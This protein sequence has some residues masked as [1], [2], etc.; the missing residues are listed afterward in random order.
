MTEANNGDDPDADARR[1]SALSLA[2]DDATGWFED[3][4]AAASTG[5]AVVP[6]D[7]VQ[8]QV[9]VEEWVRDQGDG[10]GRRALVVGCALGR[11]AELV[12]GMGYATTGFDIAPTA[13]EQAR[14]RHPDSAVDY[15]V[16]DLLDPPSQWREAFDLVVESINVQALPPALRERAVAQI[17]TLVAP[18]GNLLVVSAARLGP[19]DEAF[20][21]AGPPWPLD[22]SEIESFAG[23]PHHGGLDT[24]SV[25]LLPDTVEPDLHRWR[26][27]FTRPR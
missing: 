27:V 3:L 13:V 12:S 16:A 10:T 15:V 21:A 4:Y 14:R 20:I 17:G 7:R 6:W 25:E 23:D 19:A 9:L 26:A 22:R 5:A 1:L 8:P 2:R 18:G 24:V 11:D